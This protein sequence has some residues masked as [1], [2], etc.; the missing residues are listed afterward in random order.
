[1]ENILVTIGKDFSDEAKGIVEKL[2]NVTYGIGSEEDIRKA[3]VLIVGLE[4]KI[5]ADLMERAN[6]LK[7]I[8]TATTGLDHIDLQE[9]SKRGIE[10]ISLKNETEFL[11]TITSTAELALGMMVAL[12]RHLPAAHASVIQGAWNRNAFRGHSLNGKMLGIIGMGRLGNLMSK[13]A[14]SLNMNVLFND[15]NISGS[16]SLEELLENADI[17]SIHVHLTKETANLISI[18][19]LEAMK[20]GALVINTSRGDIVD[21]KAIVKALKS[22]HIGG[23]ATDVLSDELSFKEGGMTSPIIEYAKTHENVIITPHIGGMTHEDRKKTD[24]FIA[25]KVLDKLS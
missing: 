21:E 11:K 24:V 4:Q 19:E 16:V 12:S 22:G 7:L 25:Q 18:T 8:A 3:T 6:D 2:G 20:K 17:I 9:A 10:V 14:K 1:M 13:Y 15:P 5:G 23:Y